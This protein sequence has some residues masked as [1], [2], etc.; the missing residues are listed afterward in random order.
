MKITQNEL[1]EFAEEQNLI[2]FGKS[3]NITSNIRSLKRLMQ[4][5]LIPKP[6]WEG[7]NLSSFWVN[8]LEIKER[9]IWID[10]KIK[11]RLSYRQMK[12][13][14][15]SEQ[16]PP[17][18]SRI[19]ADIILEVEEL[20]NINPGNSE[21][22]FIKALMLYHLERREDSLKILQSLEINCNENKELLF[23]V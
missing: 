3:K 21:V 7:G 13:E 15:E 14:L 1:V 20:L 18:E 6:K 19:I 8:D 4:R 2:V 22:L 9:I 23:K 16:S 10:E 12:A 11:E 5:G 17:H